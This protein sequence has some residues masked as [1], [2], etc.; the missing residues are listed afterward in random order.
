MSRLS[1]L[2]SPNGVS[3]RKAPHDWRLIGNP[4][5]PSSMDFFAW[6]SSRHGVSKV[7]DPNC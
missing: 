7:E 3:P 4:L 5:H 6:R 2:A 1:Y